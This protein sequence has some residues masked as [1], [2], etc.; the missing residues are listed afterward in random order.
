MSPA[1]VSVLAA[2]GL[3]LAAGG[4]GCGADTAESGHDEADAP[5]AIVGNRYADGEHPSVVRLSIEE[6]GRF[7]TCTGTLIGP[8]TVVTARHC[9]ETSLS[10]GGGCKV[11]AF[12]DRV[13]AG[14]HDARA[15]RHAATRCDVLAP[16]EAPTRSRDLA[17]VQLGVP[18]RDVLFA[19]LADDTTPRGRYDTFGYGSWGEAPSFGVMCSN[20][21]DGHK[22]KASYDG[23]LGFRFGQATCTG[24]SGGPHFVRGT[25]VLAGVTSGGYAFGI[26]YERNAD[27]A[28]ERAWILAQRDAYER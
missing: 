22:R 25:N 16:R 9:L 20:R 28:A 21:S 18:V 13:G 26:A 24:D 6:D 15:E 14:T 4:L 2:L 11:T 3:A 5:D 1:R 19:T 17:T 8:R 7:F 10:D 27:V 23:A 12:V